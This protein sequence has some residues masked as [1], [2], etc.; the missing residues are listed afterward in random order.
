MD[1]VLVLPNTYF[2]R[3][4]TTDKPFSIVCAGSTFSNFQWVTARS[5]IYR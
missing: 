4:L 5:T 3:F 2:F 1:G